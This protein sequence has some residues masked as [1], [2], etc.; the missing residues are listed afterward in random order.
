LFRRE[1]FIPEQLVPDTFF[2]NF[3]FPIRV[4]AAR[5]VTRNVLIE[6]RPR[7]AGNS[8]STGWK[9]IAGVARDL[10]DLRLRRL[11]EGW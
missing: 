7:R 10:V 3:E 6:C 4:L 8:K 2:L 9:R 11:T 1:L 5:R